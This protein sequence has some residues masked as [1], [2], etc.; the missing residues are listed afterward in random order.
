MWETRWKLK[1]NYNE[2][3]VEREVDAVVKAVERGEFRRA[4]ERES[5]TVK[6]AALSKIVH[7]LQIRVES[8]AGLSGPVQDRTAAPVQHLP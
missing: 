7:N 2:I 5:M 3:D 1:M 4:T 6:L 8:D